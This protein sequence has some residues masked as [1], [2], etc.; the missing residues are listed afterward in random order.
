MVIVRGLVLA[1]PEWSK[2]SIMESRFERF[3]DRPAQ[4]SS[5]VL[6]EER[7][8]ALNPPQRGLGVTGKSSIPWEKIRSLVW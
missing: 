1:S 3:I 8:D 5:G 6:I 2:A 4:R 7:L